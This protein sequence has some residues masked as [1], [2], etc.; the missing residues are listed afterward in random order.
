VEEIKFG[1][2]Q[3]HRSLSTGEGEGG[4]GRTEL[5]NHKRSVATE[6]QSELLKLVSK[7][8]KI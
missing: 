1:F 8:A 7:K 2:V 5:Q 6:D 4:R 3:K